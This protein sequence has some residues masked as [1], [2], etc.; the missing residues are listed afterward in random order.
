MARLP[1]HV[2]EWTKQLVEN[3]YCKIHVHVYKL[4]KTYWEGSTMT[5]VKIDKGKGRKGS[6]REDFWLACSAS[7][8]EKGDVFLYY[9]G[10]YKIFSKWYF[11]MEKEFPCYPTGWSLP[12]EAP[13]TSEAPQ[14]PHSCTE[15]TRLLGLVSQDSLEIMWNK[16][17]KKV[18]QWFCVFL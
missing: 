5:P 9:L 11:T 15:G 1:Y 16:L 8:L 14:L 2:L 7:N 18:V 13:P 12:S 10:N 17:E 4:I 6:S 3:L